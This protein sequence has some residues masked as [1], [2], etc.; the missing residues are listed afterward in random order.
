MRRLFVLE[1]EWKNGAG[2]HPLFLAELE[3]CSFELRASYRNILFEVE[4]ISKPGSFFQAINLT[5]V[6]KLLNNLAGY[7]KINEW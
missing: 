5:S 4:L 3:D 6:S 7:G 1:L 2:L